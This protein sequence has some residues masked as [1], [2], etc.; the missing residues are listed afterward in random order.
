MEGLD[1]RFTTSSSNATYTAA[2]PPSNTRM[3]QFASPLDIQSV[4]LSADGIDEQAAQDNLGGSPAD[5]RMSVGYVPDSCTQAS[6]SDSCPANVTYNVTTAPDLAISDNT[7]R[8]SA[9][10]TINVPANSTVSSIS[11]LVDIVHTWIGDLKVIL[12]S[13][14]GT[15]AVLHNRTGSSTNNIIRTYN[16]SSYTALSSMMNTSTAGTWTLSVGDY[17]WGDIGALNRWGIGLTYAPSSSSSIP[18]AGMPE[19]PQA[20]Q[21]ALQTQIFYDDFESSLT[22]KWVETG[23]GDWTTTTS[24]NHFVAIP[25]GHDASNLVLHSDNC[26]TSCTL[27]FKDSLDLTSYS[28][29]TLSFWRFVDSSLDGDEYLKVDLYNGTAWDTI[30]HWSHNL[31]GDDHI[32]HNESYDLASYLNTTNFKL[33]LVTHQSSVAEDVQLDDIMI[34]AT[35]GTM[36][37]R[38]ISV[39]EDFELGLDGWIQSGDSDWTTRSPSTILPGSASGNMVAYSSNC[40]RLCIIT[41]SPA[42]LSSQTS[43]TLTLDRFVSSRLDAGEYLRVELYNGSSWSTAFDWQASAD[44]DDSIWH[45][46]SYDLPSSYLV[47]DMQVRITARSST[48]S[49]IAMVDNVSIQGSAQM[50]ANASDYS[51]YIADTDDYEVLAYSKNGTYL[52]V[53]VDR[54]SGGLG[55][56]WDAAFGPDGHMYISDYTYTKIRKYDGTTGAPISG[57]AGW[58]N[59]TGVPL[60]L[61]WN[62]NSLYVATLYG[63]EKFSS[64]GTNLGF[65]GD[66]SNY[67]SDPLA[68]AVVFSYDLAFCSDGHMY[69]ADR[70][71]DK[72]FYYNSSDGS[73]LGEISGTSTD[74]P[75]T[76]KAA[77]LTCGTAMSGSGDSLYQSGDD[78]G[79]IN[80]INPSSGSLRQAITSLVD[81]PF[82]MD[83]D[84]DGILYV[85]NKDDDNVLKIVSGTSTVFAA[86]TSGNGLDDPRGVTI[87]PVYSASAQEA[88]GSAEIHTQNEEPEISILHGDAVVS[89]SILIQD[90]SSL[91][92]QATDP[93]GD[94]VTITLTRDNR[95]PDEAVYITDHLNGTATILVN[96]ANVTAGTYLLW[97][98]AS[99]SHGNS[100]GE[101]YT[102]IIP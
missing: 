82:G 93:D 27:T 28:S 13:P 76:Y 26:D 23:E 81:E 22:A 62:G 100:N 47:S 69:V 14:D 65:F 38:P 33:R 84:G 17:A 11:V 101:P 12:T 3:V 90:I 30:Y 95:L 5:I 78:R 19:P 75:N 59:T 43:A 41:L 67:P 7:Q 42:D 87:G 31:G 85:A 56:A 34:N 80:E 53:F 92:I 20:P 60:G 10:S 91:T 97:I 48:S 66:A 50:P 40:D 46:E 45:S 35:S 73:H 39:S 36:H 37:T 57:F 77:G 4:T 58:A 83:M 44:E 55:K 1:I 79:R 16:S 51:V 54:G 8:Q 89:G 15:Q 102:V 6:S 21:P 52:G 71:S 25:P 18:P 63:I 29:A 70:S 98:E 86:E 99:D 94:P 49:E 74:P 68:P 64:S 96:P 2:V 88:S 72:V 61:T 9:T 32:W 24:Q